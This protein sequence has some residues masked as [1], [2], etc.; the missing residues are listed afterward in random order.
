MHRRRCEFRGV[1]EF[2][3]KQPVMNHNSLKLDLQIEFNSCKPQKRLDFYLFGAA[4]THRWRCGFGGSFKS[5][6]D[7]PTVMQFPVFSPPNP[8][9]TEVC[10]EGWNRGSRFR[11]WVLIWVV[12]L[13][14]ELGL[15]LGSYETVKHMAHGIGIRWWWGTQPNWASGLGLGLDTRRFEAAKMMGEGSNDGGERGTIGLWVWVRG[16]I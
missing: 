6:I 13:G 11:V 3:Y 4:Y 2:G 16:W 1:R 10:G 12:V 9:P 5:S 7:I 14:L 15:D 8:Y